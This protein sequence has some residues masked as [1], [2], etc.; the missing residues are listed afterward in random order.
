MLHLQQAELNKLDFNLLTTIK[1]REYVKTRK[2]KQRKYSKSVKRTLES[3]LYVE[4]SQNIT[5][6]KEK[7]CGAVFHTLFTEPMWILMDCNKI[8][9]SLHFMCEHKI[10]QPANFSH[11]YK[12]E[13]Y[14]CK[15]KWIYA[16]HSCWSIGE[17]MNHLV[18]DE[19]S[20]SNLELLSYL[21][22]W[23][24]GHA[25]R[26]MLIVHSRFQS[27]KCLT[28]NAFL[29]QRLRRWTLR[30]YCMTASHKYA[31]LARKL[32]TSNQD[33][34][35]DMHYT[36]HDG[37]CILTTY[38]C[39]GEFDCPDET[40]E[41]NCGLILCSDQKLSSSDYN[42]NVTSSN[43]C[44]CSD[45]C[46]QCSNGQCISLQMRCDGF[47]ECY[48]GT[49]ELF[50]DLIEIYQ[51]QVKENYHILKYEVKLHHWTNMCTNRTR[52]RLNLAL[53]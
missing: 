15:S 24:L 38:I 36:C 11:V 8:Y 30:D 17:I 10:P 45:M 41:K 40:D 48:D 16:N 9:E 39:D 52:D 43:V 20:L 46:F 14:W 31:L 19:F 29:H 33:C 35:N 1:Y 51:Q 25:S 53:Q 3:I 18:I 7:L 32:I 44:T 27:M 26:H 37:T 42:S 22:A 6:E 2:A 49:D 23:S 34:N 5:K 21:T 4:S 13:T 12:R 50:C 47:Q 28:T